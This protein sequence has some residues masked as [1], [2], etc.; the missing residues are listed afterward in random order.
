M[1]T[2]TE[3]HSSAAVLHRDVQSVEDQRGRRYLL[4]KRSRDAWLLLDPTT[5]ESVYR[6][7][8]QLSLLAGASPL[9]TALE[10]LD[11]AALDRLLGSGD[12]GGLADAEGTP[13]EALERLAGAAHS[14]RILGLVVALADRGPTAVRTLLTE[15]TLC[16]SDLHGALAE[17]VAADLLTESS[18]AGERAYAATADAERAVALLRGDAADGE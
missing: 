1:P 14:P 17:L 10:G 16:E 6:D 5:G 18:V 2:A 3:T 12:G 7:P 11:D 13:S 8:S 15:T 9:E 4:E